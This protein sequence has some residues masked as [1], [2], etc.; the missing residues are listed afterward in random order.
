MERYRDGPAGQHGMVGWGGPPGRRGEAAKARAQAERHGKETTRS[1]SLARCARLCLF[2]VF[3]GSLC[4][5]QRR[6]D[7]TL[8]MWPPLPHMAAG[9]APKQRPLEPARLTRRRAGRA[10]GTNEKAQPLLLVGSLLKIGSRAACRYVCCARPEPETRCALH[11][12]VRADIAQ[13]KSMWCA[14]GGG[15]RPAGRGPPASK[16]SFTDTATG[17]AAHSDTVGRCAPGCDSLSQPRTAPVQKSRWHRAA[18]PTRRSAT[19]CAA[20]RPLL[21][22]KSIQSSTMIAQRC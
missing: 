11:G 19:R 14:G 8:H 22:Q 1:N 2:C 9:Q 20:A 16:L 15:G 18:R 5:P 17:G 21:P 3:G 6:G 7:S 10:A 12:T 4:A 13:V